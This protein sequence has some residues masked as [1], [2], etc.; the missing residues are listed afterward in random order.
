M[1]LSVDQLF[2]FPHKRF[3]A[4]RIFFKIFVYLASGSPCSDLPSR[5]LFFSIIFGPLLECFDTTVADLSNDI[6]LFVRRSD[7]EMWR[8]I[9]KWIDPVRLEQLSVMILIMYELLQWNPVW[10]LIDLDID[11]CPGGV[12]AAYLSTCSRTAPKR[13][14]IHSVWFGRTSCLQ[15]T[16]RL[17][18]KINVNNK[19]K[20]W[21]RFI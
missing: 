6:L 13:I 3:P 12:L 10:S 9:Y 8:Y 14:T 1:R 11:W 4:F 16:T 21:C 2:R 7:L 15:T 5:S 19:R 20:Y 17:I 18:Y